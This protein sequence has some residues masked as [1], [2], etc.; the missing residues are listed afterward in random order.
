[1]TYF[2]AEEAMIQIIFEEA[3]YVSSTSETDM[4]KIAFIDTTLFFDF[5]G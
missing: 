1:M 5:A 3:I 4:I 2:E